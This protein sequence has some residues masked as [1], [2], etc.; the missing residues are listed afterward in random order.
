MILMEY[1]KVYLFL[2]LIMEVVIFIL[3]LKMD[4][5]WSV[6]KLANIAHDYDNDNNMDE[7]L[8][9]MKCKKRFYCFFKYYIIVYWILALLIIGFRPLLTPY[10]EWVFSL[11][12]QLFLIGNTSLLFI[13]LNCSTYRLY[14]D[15]E[16]ADE[17]LA[18]DIENQL[19]QGN[20]PLP[21]DKRRN[22]RIVG[23]IVFIESICQKKED[24]VA[25][26]VEVF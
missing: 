2:I 19:G 9:S 14:K 12:Y 3:L 24:N 11:S 20:I 6:Q 23:D 13:M 10:H 18:L 17:P 26:G 15:L 7:F 21:F 5:N 4:I 16:G 22:P 1:V 25:I 8:V